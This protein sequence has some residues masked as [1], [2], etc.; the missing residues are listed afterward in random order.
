MRSFGLQIQVPEQQV[1]APVILF[2]EEM[3]IPQILQNERLSEI[4]LRVFRQAL[5]ERFHGGIVFAHTV[6]GSSQQPEEVES[7]GWFQGQFQGCS[8]G[9]NGLRQRAGLLVD[10]AQFQPAEQGNRVARIVLNGCLKCLKRL[11]RFPCGGMGQAQPIIG[12]PCLDQ[13]R[14]GLDSRQ[15]FGNDLLIG[16][17]QFLLIQEK[18]AVGQ[19]VGCHRGFIP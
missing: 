15:I 18:C 19:T 9:V 6:L 1:A 10:G 16:Q 7:L 3:A 13:S 2:P 12:P 14:V 5:F 4:K 17:I 11:F 8:E